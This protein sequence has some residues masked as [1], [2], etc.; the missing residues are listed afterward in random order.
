MIWWREIPIPCW[1]AEYIKFT[2]SVIWMTLVL[3]EQMSPLR[4]GKMIFGKL[5]QQSGNLI[6][7]LVG[8]ILIYYV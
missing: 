1:S 4:S 2:L 8:L 3:N 7:S 5:S 6:Y